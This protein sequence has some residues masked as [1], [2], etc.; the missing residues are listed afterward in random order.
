MSNAKGQMPKGKCQMP[1]A[2]GQRPKGRMPNT[3][4]QLRRMDPG[5]LRE[6]GIQHSAFVIQP[7][8]FVIDT[9]HEID[10]ITS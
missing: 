1:K 10:A 6:I 3:T 7:L 4:G 2:K 9:N 5:Q 8:A